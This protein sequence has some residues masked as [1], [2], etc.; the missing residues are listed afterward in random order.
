MVAGEIWGSAFAQT[1]LWFAEI[2]GSR[3]YIRRTEEVSLSVASVTV[4]YNG[5]AGLQRQMD[6]LLRQTRPLQEIIVVDNA[7]IDDTGRLLAVE[8]PH[9]TVLRMPENLGVGGGFAAGLA[10]AALEKQY[11]WVWMFDQDSVPTDNALEALL[12]NA[13]SLE[14]TDREVGIVA[15][16]PIH[17]ETG[18]CYEPLLWR[19]GYVK[20]PSSMLKEPIWFVDLVI[21]SG[22]MLRRDVVEKIGLPRADL[23][24]YFLDFEYC[25]RARSHGYKIAVITSATFA[26]Q[27]GNARK[28]W[29]PGYSGLWPDRAPTS[30]YFISRNLTYAAWWLYPNRSTK[31]FAVRHLIRHAAGVVLFGSNKLACLGKMAQGFWDGRKGSLGVRFRPS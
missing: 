27:M 19:D 7:S 17:S 24:M 13:E 22:C 26:H 1:R 30:E 8:Y 10:Y 28:V 16:L 25:L 14:N 4:A 11:D 9:V 3:K 6:A 21:S 23:F 5:A 20:L 12:E 2:T 31:H 15:A 29:A 18:T